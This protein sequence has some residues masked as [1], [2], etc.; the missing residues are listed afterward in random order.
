MKAK[1]KKDWL[2]TALGGAIIAVTVLDILPGD[3]IIGVPLG[4]ALILD[5]QKWL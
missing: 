3:E 4:L 2:E 1:R 5:G